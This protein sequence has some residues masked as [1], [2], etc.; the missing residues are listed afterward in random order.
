MKKYF[1]IIT[2]IIVLLITLTGC[3]T[4]NI[5]K[6]DEFSIVSSFYPV[7]TILENIT[8]GAQN[9]KVENMTSTNIGCLHDYTLT[10][11]DLKKLEQADIFIASGVEN[12]IDSINNTYPNLKIINS[13]TDAPNIISDEQGINNHMWLDISNY[14]WQVKVITKNLI[15]CNPE[16]KTTYEENSNSYIQE[17]EELKTWAKEEFTTTKKCINFDE[18]LDY[19]KYDMNLEIYTVKTDHEQSGLSAETISSIIEYI[20][21]NNIKNIIT[22]KDSNNTNAE[23]I[24]AETGAKIYKLDTAITGNNE[25]PEAYLSA[26]EYNIEQIKTMED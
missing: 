2:L 17:L 19:L 3:T 11:T 9:V 5:V 10:T 8:Q 26:M 24:A 18:A 15:E 16:N 13:T 12:F 25:D 21:Q 6:K 20:K 4:N 23:I 22:S 1:V 7:Y 14:I